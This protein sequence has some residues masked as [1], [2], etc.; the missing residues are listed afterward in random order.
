MDKDLKER[1][2]NFTVDA[3]KFL[4]EIKSA[5]EISILKQQLTKAASSGGANYEEVQAASYRADFR[6]KIT[7]SLREMREANYWI[8]VIRRLDL[9]NKPKG[10]YLIGESKELKKNIRFNCQQSKMNLFFSFVLFNF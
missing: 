9:G 7:I 3:V 10:E 1:L 8:R 2:F 4:P 5:P 6:H